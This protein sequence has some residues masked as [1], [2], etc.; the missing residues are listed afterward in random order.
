MNKFMDILKTLQETTHAMECQVAQ[1]MSASHKFE[2]IEK[3]MND[4]EAKF[5]PLFGVKPNRFT[6]KKN[7]RPQRY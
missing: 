3:K 7:L 5:T 6:G 2:E 4:I 1:L